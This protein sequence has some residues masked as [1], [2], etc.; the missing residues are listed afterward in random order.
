[1]VQNSSI[2]RLLEAEH[3]R[4][5][6]E[7]VELEQRLQRIR[8]QIVSVEALI[9]GCIQEVQMYQMPEN[10]ALVSNPA[11]KED[12]RGDIN[13]PSKNGMESATAHVEADISDI[14]QHSASTFPE[15][16]LM[17]DEF[18]N[19]SVQDAILILMRLQPDEHLSIDAVVGDL[20]GDGLT[21]EQYK[22]AKRNVALALSSGVQMELWYR[23]LRVTGV[24]TLCYE[25]GVT[26]K[27]IGVRAG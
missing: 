5:T 8:N 6:T 14:P 26:T 22:T 23:V 17:L 4:Y 7:V 25:K 10:C 16:V 1:M 2:L 12:K 9:S 15:T 11:V 27:P 24:Y 13:Q 18:Q 3:K 19:Y 21:S 20:Y